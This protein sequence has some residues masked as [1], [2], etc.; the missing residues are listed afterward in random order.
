[1]GGGGGGGKGGGGGALLFNFL[2]MDINV[3]PV[4]RVRGVKGLREWIH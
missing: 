3:N 1:M 4:C 2:L